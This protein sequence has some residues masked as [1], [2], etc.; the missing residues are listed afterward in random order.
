MNSFDQSL[1]CVASKD[2]FVTD[3]DTKLD[4]SH[5]LH[6]CDCISQDK[7]LGVVTVSQKLA[8]WLTT[9]LSY[10]LTIHLSFVELR[11]LVP[12]HI[13]NT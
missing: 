2:C 10:M 1:T 11:V 7:Q 8:F 5:Q 6:I 3:E 13:T 12:M 9:C 4:M